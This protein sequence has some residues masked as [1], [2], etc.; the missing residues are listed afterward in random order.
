MPK[1]ASS[2][3]VISHSS[4]ERGININVDNLSM[5]CYT[6]ITN[7]SSTCQL[8]DDRY[9]TIDTETVF[10]N[11]Y[12]K[13]HQV[14][15]LHSTWRIVRHKKKYLWRLCLRMFALHMYS[16][17][18]K[19]KRN[20]TCNCLPFSSIFTARVRSTTGGNVFIL[21]TIC[22]GGVPHLRSG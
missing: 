1:S 10:I 20:T 13:T 21:S 7:C 4:T 16:L 12:A 19:V 15:I 9:I 5:F 8:R 22:G 6:F 14:T 18:G 11:C 17:C 2:Q 3:D